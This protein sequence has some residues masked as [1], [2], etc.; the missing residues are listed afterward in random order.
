MDPRQCLQTVALRTNF[1]TLRFCLGFKKC[2]G[3]E[4]EAISW[5]SYCCRPLVHTNTEPP[6]KAQ[7]DRS[8][9]LLSFC[10]SVSQ[11]V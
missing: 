1:Q 2:L 5:L 6:L 9:H 4:E 10:G 8:L 11:R 7:S 3:L